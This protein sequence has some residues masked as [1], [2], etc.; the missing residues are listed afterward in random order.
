[1]LEI[2]MD[3]FLREIEKDGE[4]CT[5]GDLLKQIAA[6]AELQI[7]LEGELDRLEQQAKVV[8]LKLNAVSIDKLPELMAE[9]KLQ[10]F[11]LHTG[12]KIEVAE[13]LYCSVPV[14]RRAE[15]YSKL[16]EDGMGDLITNAIQVDLARGQDNLAGD[17]L[18]YAEER[19]L[20]AKR[21]EKVNTASL[22]K[23]L[24]EQIDEGSEVDLSFYGA[25]LS[26]R[27]KVK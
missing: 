13:E 1:M 5:D 26:R 18:G 2:E 12:E 16:R 4:S 24:R 23:Y 20:M 14:A 9:A 22:K 11:T 3:D 8:K 21:E 15:I 25:H 6:L 27:T 7:K 10:N 19:G 17:L